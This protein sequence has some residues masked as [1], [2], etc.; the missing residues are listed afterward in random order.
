M[1]WV[2][3]AAMTACKE[4]L[5]RMEPVK[6]ELKN[7][8]WLEL[9]MAAYQKDVD[10]CARYLYVSFIHCNTYERVGRAKHRRKTVSQ[11]HHEGRHQKLSDIRL[12]DS[13]SRIGFIDW[14]TRCAQGGYN[15]GRWQKY[16]P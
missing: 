7:P 2:F 4:L 11:V 3:Q 9:V 1:I 14:T 15:G 6:E 16:E 10:L 13:G 8:T 5:K 12:H